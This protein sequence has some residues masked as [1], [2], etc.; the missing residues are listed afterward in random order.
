MSIYVLW[1][2][3]NLVA[4]HTIQ[5]EAVV[6]L[7]GSNCPYFMLHLHPDVCANHIWT[8]TSTR[9][10]FILTALCNLL[11]EFNFTSARIVKQFHGTSGSHNEGTSKFIL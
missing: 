8:Q 11:A 1:C 5:T 7:E 6:P 9:F 2:S 3:G 10:Q 4:A